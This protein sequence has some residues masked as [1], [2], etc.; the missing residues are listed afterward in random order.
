MTFSVN[1]ITLRELG[2]PH[3][4]EALIARCGSS[5]GRERAAAHGF[6]ADQ[7]VIE[8]SLARIEEVRTLLRKIKELS[9]EA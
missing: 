5:L 4:R 6:A 2:W 3:I 8:T 1:D 9:L 7:D